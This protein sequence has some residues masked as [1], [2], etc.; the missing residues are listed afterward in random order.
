MNFVA[1]DIQ[2]IVVGL[3]FLWLILS[4]FIAFDARTRHRASSPW[5]LTILLTG[6]FGLLFYYITIRTEDEDAEL[7]RKAEPRTPLVTITIGIVILLAMTTGLFTLLGLASLLPSI[8]DA[9][10][11]LLFSF[12]FIALAV[13]LIMDATSGK[14]GIE[15]T[16]SGYIGVF[17]AAGL[18]LGE[19]LNPRGELFSNHANIVFF[20][21]TF[22]S[23]L[24]WHF[25]RKR[26]LLPKIGE[27]NAG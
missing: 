12:P 14:C 5:F 22:G 21:G 11:L 8:Y 27:M 17:L 4:V 16:I 19:V 3:G 18:L 2:Q 9:H 20:V 10:E 23:P 25:T 7:K 24:I 1:T 15:L 13:V 6:V 26:V